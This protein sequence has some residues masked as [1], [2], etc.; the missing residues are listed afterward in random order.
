MDEVD[1]QAEVLLSRWNCMMGAS[2]N[3]LEQL[4]VIL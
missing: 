2:A 1:R 3:V 4:S